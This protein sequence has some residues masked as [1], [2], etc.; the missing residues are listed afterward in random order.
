M[1]QKRKFVGPKA[2]RTKILS[3]GMWHP[4]VY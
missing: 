3:S 4:V 1:T 2:V